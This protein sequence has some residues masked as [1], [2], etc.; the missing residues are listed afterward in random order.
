MKRT[1]PRILHWRGKR[2]RQRIS[3]NLFR[4]R[5]L[6]VLNAQHLYLS[7]GVV[8]SKLERITY[9]L[10]DFAVCPIDRAPDRSTFVESNCRGVRSDPNADALVGKNV[11]IPGAAW[12]IPPLNVLVYLST[13]SHFCA[14][15]MPWYRRLEPMQKVARILRSHEELLMD[16]RKAFKR[17]CQGRPR[18]NPSD[19]QTILRL[20][21]LQSDG[22]SPL[23]HTWTTT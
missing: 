17:R 3:T 22:N 11:E 10:S 16:H 4:G 14:E 19:Y 18:Q 1:F 7:L 23:S 8:I 12:S 2:C 5:V 20:S 15:S 6:G 13:T 21:H 9:L